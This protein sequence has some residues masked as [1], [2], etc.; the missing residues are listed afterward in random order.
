M[1]LLDI[2][3]T[4]KHFDQIIIMVVHIKLSFSDVVT[5]H[6]AVL[7]FN[8]ATVV[9][10]PLESFLNMDSLLRRTDKPTII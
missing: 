5:C 6:V 8:S 7:S 9:A 10:D 1:F 4:D 2:I 3:S